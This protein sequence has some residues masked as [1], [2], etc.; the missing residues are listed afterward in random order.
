MSI[1]VDGMVGAENTTREVGLAY[2]VFIAGLPFSFLA[3]IAIKRVK[4][5]LDSLKRL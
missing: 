3:N 5:L 2:W 1:F 4:N